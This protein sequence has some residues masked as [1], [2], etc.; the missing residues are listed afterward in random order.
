MCTIE[1]WRSNKLVQVVQSNRMYTQHYFIMK[2]PSEPLLCALYSWMALQN[3]TWYVKVVLTDWS[4]TGLPFN[5]AAGSGSTSRG[6]S[7]LKCPILQF[8]WWPKVISLFSKRSMLSVY[9]HRSLQTPTSQ[10]WELGIGPEWT[11]RPF[12]GHYLILSP[13]LQSLF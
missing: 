11:F 3:K 5:V 1:N 9:V 2:L 13:L 10:L 6:E 7:F 12:Q 4:A 8:N